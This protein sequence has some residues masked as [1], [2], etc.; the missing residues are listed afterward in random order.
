MS[1]LGA[2][3]PHRPI[4]SPYRLHVGDSPFT[5]VVG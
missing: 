1:M 3:P 4:A 5:V 2:T